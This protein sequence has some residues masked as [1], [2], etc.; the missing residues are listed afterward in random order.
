MRNL[1]QFPK[2]GEGLLEQLREALIQR[3]QNGTDKQARYRPKNPDKK[4]LG[5][6][7]IRKL[8]K[9][10]RELIRKLEQQLAA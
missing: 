1:N 5:D 7:V 6:P 4:P 10:E 2:P 8:T 3:Y 9:K